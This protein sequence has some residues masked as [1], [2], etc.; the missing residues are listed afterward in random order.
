[1]SNQFE[2]LIY[3]STCSGMKW[4]TLKCSSPTYGLDFR[5]A[6]FIFTILCCSA[7][8]GLTS[9]AL[10][11]SGEGRHLDAVVGKRVKTI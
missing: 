11:G 4:H 7:V 6:F 8:N 9:L 5:P 2:L 1:M 10:S 3:I